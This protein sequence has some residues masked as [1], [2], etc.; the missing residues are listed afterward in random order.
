MMCTST[1]QSSTPL[2]DPPACVHLSASTTP[3]IALVAAPPTLPGSSGAG[4]GKGSCLFFG[5]VFLLGR[6]WVVMVAIRW[7]RVVLWLL[8][9]SFCWGVGVGEVSMRVCVRVYYD[10]SN[11]PCWKCAFRTSVCLPTAPPHI[12]H[13]NL[14]F[15]KY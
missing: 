6:W 4:G 5:V 9:M 8:L 1:T 14:S 15:F 12:T 13:D 2:S 11:K 3:R 7:T 10:D